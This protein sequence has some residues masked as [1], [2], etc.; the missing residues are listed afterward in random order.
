M[1]SSIGPTYHND[2]NQSLI[3]WKMRLQIERVAKVNLPAFSIVL[4]SLMLLYEQT[5]DERKIFRN[6]I[7]IEVGL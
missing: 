5:T 2:S 6:S 4:L 7:G 3:S 1:E